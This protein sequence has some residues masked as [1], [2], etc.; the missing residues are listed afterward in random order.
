MVILRQSTLLF[1]LFFWV[2]VGFASCDII[3]KVQNLMLPILYWKLQVQARKFYGGPAATCSCA[4]QR[5]PRP[6]CTRSHYP[7]PA[8]CSSLA[9][10]RRL[11]RHPPACS[12]TS[13]QPRGSGRRREAAAEE[14]STAARPMAL[15]T[16][17][18]AEGRESRDIFTAINSF[19]DFDLEINYVVKLLLSADHANY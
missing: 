4:R 13:R 19:N 16:P 6:I 2:A 17:T 7:S 18:D 15:R 3:W 5:A 10:T 14:A 1:L 11:Q 12:L 8:G 9:A